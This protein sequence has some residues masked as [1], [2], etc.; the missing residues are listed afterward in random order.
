MIG[1]LVLVSGGGGEQ[2]SE[3]GALAG[4]I[5]IDGSSTVYPISEAVA[6][7]AASKLA[8]IAAERS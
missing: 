8:V 3:E 6:A 1:R 4:P 5:E 7:R 2:G